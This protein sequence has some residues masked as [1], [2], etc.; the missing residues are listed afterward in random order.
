M[1]DRPRVRFYLADL[2]MAAIVC[3]LYLALFTSGRDLSPV[4]VTMHSLLIG[5]AVAG[6]VLFRQR[7]GADLR[8]MRPALFDEAARNAGS[9]PSLRRSAGIT[10]PIHRLA[11]EGFL[12][13][14]RSPRPAG[15]RDRYSGDRADWKAWRS[16]LGIDSHWLLLLDD[17]R[18][19][20]RG[21][22][23]IISDAFDRSS[24]RSM[25]FV[26][27][28]AEDLPALPAAPSPS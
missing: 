15:C 10:E 12:G 14:D 24:L 18:P 6:W 9:V 8:G 5:T 2:I 19:A 16:L 13:H 3:G 1:A 21:S 17:D 11:D 27:H 4:E 20:W 26:D 23:S 22:L 25:R 7:R 28:R